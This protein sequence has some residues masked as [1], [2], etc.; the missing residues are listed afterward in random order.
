MMTQKNMLGFCYFTMF[1]SYHRSQHVGIG[2]LLSQFTFRPSARLPC[3]RR[4]GVWER[5]IPCTGGTLRCC[6]SY[7]WKKTKTNGGCESGYLVQSLNMCKIYEHG[8]LKLEISLL[9]TTQENGP[10]F[11]SYSGFPKYVETVIT[12]SAQPS[13]ELPV[14]DAGA[15]RVEER[16]FGEAVVRSEACRRRG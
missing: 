15:G 14:E 11:C 12:H 1:H 3:V 8:T 13:Q 10:A 5:R 7:S 6:N 16:A 2:S 4:G 9:L